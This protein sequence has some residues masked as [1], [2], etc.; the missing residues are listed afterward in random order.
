MSGCAKPFTG[1]PDLVGRAQVV[2]GV[3]E[4]TLGGEPRLFTLC[5]APTGDRV[6]ALAPVGLWAR[7]V[8]CK[9]CTRRLRSKP[10]LQSLD[11]AAARAPK[12][13]S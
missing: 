11:A 9:A 2:H 3:I 6:H 8:T 4:E 7:R 13:G 10:Q 1:I 5:G 12:R